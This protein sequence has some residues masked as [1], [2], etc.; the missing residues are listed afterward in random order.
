MFERGTT[1]GGTQDGGSPDGSNPALE[2]LQRIPGFQV[3]TMRGMSLGDF[4]PFIDCDFLKHNPVVTASRTTVDTHIAVPFEAITDKRS[5]IY[6]QHPNLD[7]ASYDW[8]RLIE[9]SLWHMAI[10]VSRLGIQVSPLQPDA[11]IRV[12]MLSAPEV[13]EIEFNGFKERNGISFL[14]ALHHALG[15]RGS[16]LTSSTPYGTPTESRVITFSA[17][18]YVEP[19]FAAVARRSLD[20]SVGIIP[21]IRSV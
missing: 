5:F 1:G 18:P 9:A 7:P 12:G 15:N 11:P 10:E 2:A 13:A 21:V 3:Y 8:D 4:V 17:P 19:Q 6:T 14:K 20:A 16:L